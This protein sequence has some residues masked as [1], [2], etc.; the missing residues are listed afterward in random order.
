MAQRR[1]Q[2]FWGGKKNPGNHW[3]TKQWIKKDILWSFFIVMTPEVK[4]AENV[5][6]FRYIDIDIIPK[7]IYCTCVW[8]L[9]LPVVCSVTAA[10]NSFGWVPLFRTGC[11]RQIAWSK[12][13]HFQNATRDSECKN[14]EWVY[15]L[16]FW[17]IIIC[18]HVLLFCGILSIFPVFLGV[19]YNKRWISKSCN[20]RW[21][22]R[23]QKL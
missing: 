21:Q 13:L 23:S 19:R 12:C 6:I 18:D 17:G 11:T 2:S 1:R 14:L 16:K 10:C 9:M 8:P 20:V 15:T 4:S 5:Y 7:N 22:N 3:A